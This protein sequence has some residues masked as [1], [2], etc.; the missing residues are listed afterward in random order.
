MSLYIAAGFNRAG[1]VEPTGVLHVQVRSLEFLECTS[2]QKKKF[3]FKIR[4]GENKQ[5]STYLKYRV[6]KYSYIYVRI[7][8]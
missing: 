5:D 2:V 7:T 4:N 6:G 3:S 8:F 1:G